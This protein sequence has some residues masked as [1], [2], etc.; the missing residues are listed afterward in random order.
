MFDK[1]DMEYL[2]YQACGKLL[3]E[4]KN[5]INMIH[6]GII[7]TREH[8]LLGTARE[9]LGAPIQEGRIRLYAMSFNR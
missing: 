7:L 2:L 3:Q 6:V 9:P 8:P 5:A 1:A 4:I